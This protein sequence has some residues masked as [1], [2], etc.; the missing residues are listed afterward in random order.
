[1]TDL[2]PLLLA[3]STQSGNGK[4]ASLAI[5]APSKL[6]LNFLAF[7]IAW[8]SAST[9]DVCPVPDASNCKFLE[10]T[11]VLDFVCLHI[12]DANIRSDS[13]VSLGF[14]IVT[15]FNLSMLSVI[16]SLS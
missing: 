14:E 8:L 12:L 2:I 6:K 15:Y 4:N 7:S 3:I 13:S 11:M 10:R 1:M 16:E 9:L 5:T